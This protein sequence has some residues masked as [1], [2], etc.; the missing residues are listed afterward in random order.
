M[1]NLMKVVLSNEY[2]DPELKKSCQSQTCTWHLGWW[3]LI[4]SFPAFEAISNRLPPSTETSSPSSGMPATR[5]GKDADRPSEGH[6]DTSSAGLWFWYDAPQTNAD[7]LASASSEDSYDP[8]GSPSL[9]RDEE[10][11]EVEWDLAV[12][13]NRNEEL[14]QRNSVKQF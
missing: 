5:T 7:T 8:G 13:H 2:E 3:G 9:G 1:H 6:P 14:R 10:D 11:M 4:I 12:T